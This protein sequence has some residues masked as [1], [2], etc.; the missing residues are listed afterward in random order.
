MLR[1]P[2]LSPGSNALVAAFL[3]ASAI[4]SIALLAVRNLYDDEISSLNI[5]SG[6]VSSIL[7][8]SAVADVH[9]PGM[10]LL[11]HLAFCIIPSFRW[12]NLFSAA[13][14]YTGL[15]VFLLQVTPLLARIRSKVCFL[16]LAT[17]HPQLLMWG[18]TYRWYGWWTGI[19]LIAVTFALQPRHPEPAIS[20][21]RASVVGFLLSCLF[22]LNY[23]TFL[24]AFALAAAMLLRYGS[25]PG[26]QSLVPMLGAAGIFLALSA[27]QFPTMIAVH[28]PS[29]PSQRAGVA[30][31][32]LHLLQSLAASEAYLPWHPLA[33][34]ADLLFAVACVYSV[35]GLLRLIRSRRN[36]VPSE[37]SP[38]CENDAL[39][40]ILFFGLLFFLL[41]AGSG[42]GGKPR[43]G[44]LLIPAL[45]PAVGLVVGT[46]RPRAQTAI[47]TFVAL[48]I[49]VGVG[50]LTGRSGLAKASMIGRPEK[51]VAFIRATSG[52][53][54]SVV[55]TYDAILGFTVRQADL[56]GT[57]V[58]TQFREPVLGGPQYLPTGNCA[59]AHLY[60]VQSYVGAEDST[61]RALRQ[62]LESAVRFIDGT[63]RTDYFSFDP[64]AARKRSLAHIPGLGNG[65]SAAAVLPDYRYVVISGSIDPR[66]IS[67]LRQS[68]PDYVSGLGFSTEDPAFTP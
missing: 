45:A 26:Q 22:Y 62:E 34:A 41:V 49:A 68:M 65:L 54:C 25:R 37:S 28:L 27:P 8:H 58:V 20:F 35:V 39:A 44:L 32:S 5:I 7:R 3:L 67:A 24:F 36:S 33:I 4:I 66:Q 63:P 60:T 57:V 30:N 23:I 56:P 47:L 13:V 21:A 15:A 18:V 29:S 55:V 31:S 42:L 19:A 59:H 1:K 17:L 61:I 16:L 38:L 40:S 50:H 6:S 9:P 48:W 14:L 10:Y 46:L 64:D 11:A 43:N 53:D 12:M 52:A 2:T 51:V